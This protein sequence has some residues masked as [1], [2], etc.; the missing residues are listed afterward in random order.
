MHFFRLL[1]PSCGCKGNAVAG[2]EMATNETRMT[3][4]SKVNF[5]GILF[6]NHP[7]PKSLTELEFEFYLLSTM[8]HEP[9][10]TTATGSS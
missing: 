7:G 9:L 2:T 4:G 10:H 8:Y 1:I 6:R 3:G 5:G